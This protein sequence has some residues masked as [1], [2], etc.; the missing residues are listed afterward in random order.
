MER[1]VV[2]V[3]LLNEQKEIEIERNEKFIEEI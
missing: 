1:N 2:N 3:K